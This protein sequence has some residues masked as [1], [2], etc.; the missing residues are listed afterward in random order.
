MSTAIIITL[1]VCATGVVIAGLRVY[2]QKK[3]FKDLIDK[4]IF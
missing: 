1:I 3:I 2:A 4:D